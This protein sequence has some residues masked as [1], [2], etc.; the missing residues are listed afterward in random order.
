MRSVRELVGVSLAALSL[1]TVP[2]AIL[3]MGG[4]LQ[5]NGFADADRHANRWLGCLVIAAGLSPLATLIVLL[6]AW[7]GKRAA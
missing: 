1:L 5:G 7:R 3:A 2:M 6:R 4:M